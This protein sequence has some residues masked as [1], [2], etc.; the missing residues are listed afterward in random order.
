MRQIKIP[1]QIQKFL[2]LDFNAESSCSSINIAYKKLSKEGKPVVSIVI[3][4]YNEEANIIPTLG[5]LANNLTSKIV[6]IIV[7]NNNSTDRTEAIAKLCGVKCILESKQGITNARNAGLSQATGTY[8]L[9]AD[10]DTIYPEDWIDQMVDPLL[11]FSDTALTY[12]QFSLI[13]T[14]STSRTVYYFYEKLAEIT[15]M[16]NRSRKDEAVNVYGFNSGFRRL[17]GLDVDGFN[18][19]NGTNEDGWLALKLRNKGFGRL[20]CV[21]SR[22]TLVWTTDR[23]IQLD[24]GL[25]KAILKRANRILK[26]A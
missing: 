17:Q 14:G 4:A 1:K 19:P 23:R 5:S 20:H 26:K 8:I 7:V 15:R 18:H 21:T 12:G 9:N 25:F 16:I 3:P 11:N 22:K 6:E 24:G 10:A 2:T 13:P